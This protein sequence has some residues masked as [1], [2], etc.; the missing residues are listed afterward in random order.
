[1]FGIGPYEFALVGLLAVLLFGKRLPEVARS[2]GKGV[3]EFKKGLQGIEEEIEEAAQAQ[4]KITQV[5]EPE[6]AVEKEEPAAPKFE[7]PEVDEPD[8]EQQPVGHTSD[9]SRDTGST[10]AN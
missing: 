2:L 9:E 8:Q 7:P 6:E 1:M 10:A 5:A 4:P 3:M